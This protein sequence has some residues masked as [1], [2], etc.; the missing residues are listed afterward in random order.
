MP[1]TAK[2]LHSLAANLESNGIT[3]A[4]ICTVAAHEIERLTAERDG[5]REA[6][7]N[8]DAALRSKDAAM[9]VLFDRMRAAGVDFSDLIP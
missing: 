5:E 8:A 9:S 6:R 2:E 3:G 7:H 4:V 1:D